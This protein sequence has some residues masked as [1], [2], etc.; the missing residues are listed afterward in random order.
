MGEREDADTDA[1]VRVT[2]TIAAV[3]ADADGTLVTSNKKVTPRA[4]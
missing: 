4:I 2:Q 1:S 3:P